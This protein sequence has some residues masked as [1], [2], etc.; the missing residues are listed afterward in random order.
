MMK[1]IFTILI[2]IFASS[3]CDAQTP[4]ALDT[5]FSS[6]GLLVSVGSRLG[7]HVLVQND[8]KIIVACNPFG[9]GQ[10]YIKRFNTDGSV[11]ATFGN[12]GTCNIS[13]AE[14]ATR[15]TGMEFYNNNIYLCGTTTTNIGGTNTYVYVAAITANGTILNTFGIN[16]YVK[17]NTAPKL[18]TCADL[19]INNQGD[20]YVAGTKSFQELFI[21][22]LKNNGILDNS[23]DTDG[24]NYMNTNNPNQWFEIVDIDIDKSDKIIL[25]GKK[26][27]ANNGNNDPN[28]WN[29]MLLKYNTNGSLDN[30]FANAGV[31]LYNSNITSF[32]ESKKVLITPNNDYFVCGDTY[33][34]VD[35]DYTVLKIKNNGNIDNTFAN[36]GWAIHDLEYNNEMENPLN[37]ALMNDGRI[38]I[39]GNQGS[40]DTVYFSLFMLKNDGTRDNNFAPNGLFKH[41]FNL[42]NN[43]SSSGMGI[44]S[45]GKIVL[46]GYTRTCANGNCGPLY[47]AVSQYFGGDSE[48][49]ATIANNDLQS[50]IYVY[51]NPISQNQNLKILNLS[52]K[53]INEIKLFSIDAKEIN[54]RVDSDKNEIHFPSN[55]SI[56]MYYLKIKTERG[57]VNK[58]IHI[59]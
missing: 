25:A 41:I 51:P 24:V 14:I 43:S 31:G 40:G 23:F 11:D 18:Y 34:G 30:T 53:K 50:N 35:Y 57:N 59:R 12:A 38:L 5:S 4:C 20:I 6:D 10:S 22:K 17:F 37:A 27:R 33:D 47:M 42:N 56:G 28:F 39:T 54:I 1:H 8:G 26:Y 46:A 9:N 49:P 29:I 15:I 32:D 2:L 21:L 36:A 45:E 58:Q 48:A 52:L 19:A 13:L 55:L 44:S 3:F 16:G 7:E